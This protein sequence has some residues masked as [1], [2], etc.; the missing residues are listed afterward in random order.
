[1]A[2]EGYRLG[3]LSL[4]EVAEMLDFTVNEADGFLKQRKIELLMTGV[5]VKND[6]EELLKLLK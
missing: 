2:I 1:M 6:S 4:G 5:D 3:I